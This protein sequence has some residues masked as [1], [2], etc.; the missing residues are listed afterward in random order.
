MTRRTRRPKRKRE[1]EP[2]FRYPPHLDVLRLPVPVNGRTAYVVVCDACQRETGW[3]SQARHV[4]AS[5]LRRHHRCG[6]SRGQ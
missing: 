6:V 4:R 3:Y 5:F 1:G 2:A